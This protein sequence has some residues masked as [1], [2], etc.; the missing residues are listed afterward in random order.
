[1]KLFI[2]CI[3]YSKKYSQRAKGKNIHCA[4]KNLE[5]I[6]IKPRSQASEYFVL[7]KK[8]HISPKLIC[9]NRYLWWTTI[10]WAI[11]SYQFFLFVHDTVFSV[12]WW[13]ATCLHAN[14]FAKAIGS[15]ILCPAWHLPFGHSWHCLMWCDQPTNQPMHHT[16]EVYSIIT[17]N[18]SSNWFFVLNNLLRRIHFIHTTNSHT[19]K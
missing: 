16:N 2:F 1:M 9:R 15:F 10:L 3:L 12:W 14:I 19:N 6:G 18:T 4:S 8:I 13:S 11:V 7:L 5:K 17:N